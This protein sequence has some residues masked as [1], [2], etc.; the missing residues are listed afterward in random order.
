MTHKEA[1][2]AHFER[3]KLHHKKLAA[4]HKD[5]AEK[6]EDGPHKEFHEAAAA[7]HSQFAEQNSDALRDLERAAGAGGDLGKGFSIIPTSD[8]PRPRLIPR[9]GQRDPQVERTQVPDNLENF[10]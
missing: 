1:W 6:C 10:A 2:A 7:E 4:L 8:A 3:H 5:A 9:E